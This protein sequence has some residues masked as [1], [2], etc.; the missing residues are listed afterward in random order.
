MLRNI[1]L[2][3]AGTAVLNFPPT[4]FRLEPGLFLVQVA[5]GC[6]RGDRMVGDGE[7]ALL[8]RH[9]GEPDLKPATADEV[10]RPVQRG[11]SGPR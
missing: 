11:A 4:E 10:V 6:W 8:V 2:N 5:A 7:T 9:P 1:V 3:S